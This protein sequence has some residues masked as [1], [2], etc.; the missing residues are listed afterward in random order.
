MALP[1]PAPEHS[2]TLSCVLTA[3]RLPRAGDML[4]EAVAAKTPLGLEVLFT[5]IALPPAGAKATGG[6]A[7]LQPFSSTDLS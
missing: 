4:R 5:A 2:L 3:N 1:C 6:A 7:M